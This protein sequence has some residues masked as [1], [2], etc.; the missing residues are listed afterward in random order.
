MGNFKGH[1]FPGSL[2]LVLAIFYFLRSLNVSFLRPLRTKQFWIT[3][4]A[5]GFAFY[6][7]LGAILEFFDAL[8]PNANF[9]ESHLD[10][11]HITSIVCL[12]GLVTL[13][14]LYKVIEGAGWGISIPAGLFFISIMF[15]AHPQENDLGTFAHKFTAYL[16]CITA[17]SRAMEFLVGLHSNPSHQS[18]VHNIVASWQRSGRRFSRNF[19]LLDLPH[20]FFGW[21]CCLGS[22]CYDIR[23]SRDEKL[24]REEVLAGLHYAY[25]NPT[26]YQTIFPLLTS[27]SLFLNGVWWW[28]MAVS[29]FLY[30][31]SIPET[32]WNGHMAVH[33]AYSHLI[34]PHVLWVTAL[35]VVVSFV[36]KWVDR[37]WY[38]HTTG[39]GAAMAGG[40]VG[41]ARDEEQGYFNGSTNNDGDE[42]S[43]A[44]T[45]ISSQDL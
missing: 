12:A 16:F 1:A 31:E 24:E 13:L 38:Y 21:C 23:R 19:C 36:L 39:H 10:H 30:P 44:C 43:I 3:F 11:I 8:I 2:M 32:G 18:K 7:A 34:Y 9:S 37:R 6:G 27:Y 4:E 42:V 40:I 33:Y 22:C 15:T 41:G 26:V 25:T 5:A 28:E 14:H 20:Y 29:F 35:Y 17:F 45:P